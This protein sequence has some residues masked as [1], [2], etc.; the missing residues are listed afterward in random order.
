MA[1]QQWG[2]KFRKFGGRRY[3]IGTWHPTKSAA[4]SKAKLLRGKGYKVRT[5]RQQGQ[6]VIYA[7]PDPFK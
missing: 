7:N 1:K 4:Q 3:R 5:V 2:Y 6:Y